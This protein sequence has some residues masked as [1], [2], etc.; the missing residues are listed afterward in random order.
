[1]AARCWWLAPGKM[2]AAVAKTVVVQR[3]VV[4]FGWRVKG[5]NTVVVLLF[6]G[7]DGQGNRRSHDSIE[8]TVLALVWKPKKWQHH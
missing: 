5:W 1:M 2:V 6:V 8:A 3:E 4:G 7:R